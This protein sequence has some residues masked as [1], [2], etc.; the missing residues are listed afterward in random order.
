[1]TR[2][3]WI[4][5]AMLALIV[6][7][8]A[9]AAAAQQRSA[10]SLL[11]EGVNQ[12]L[13]MG[14]LT[15]AIATYRRILD[16]HARNR[17]VG[18]QAL[19]NLGRAY[20]KLGAAEA[21]AAYQRLLR[22]Y[23]DQPEPV[24]FARVRL[25]ALD[26]GRMVAG[27][28]ATA[29][30]YSMVFA[31]LPALRL[32]DAAH[33][34]FS[35]S[36]DQ[37]VLRMPADRSDAKLGAGL[38]VVSNGGVVLR[39]LVPARREVGLNNPRWSPDG[40]YIAYREASWVGADTSFG[41]IKI[42]PAEG[43]P[44]RT[45]TTEHYGLTGARGGFFWTP[46]SR[47]LTVVARKA[48]V[49]MDLAGKVIRTVPFE[50]YHLTQVTGYS[51]DGRWLAFHK[52]PP[53]TQQ[54][55]MNI[56]LMP[57]EGG[58]AIQLT[59][60]GEWNAWPTWT[61]DGRGLYFISDR[62]GSSNVWKIN[63]DPRSGL[64]QGEP[65]Q[66][67]SYTDVAVRHPRVLQGGK[68][69]FALIQETGTIRV[70]S[71]SDPA[72]TRALARGSDPRVSPDGQTVY[73]IGQ[74]VRPR[75]IFAVSTAEG[76]GAPRRVSTSG[77]DDHAFPSFSLSPDGRAVAFFSQDEGHA[78]LQVVETA[79]GAARELVRIASREQLVPA[80][81]PNGTQLAYSTGNAMYVIPAGPTRGEVRKIAELHDVEGWT[82]RW[83]PDGRHIA[84]L[85]WTQP[86]S[87]NAVVVVPASGG[88]PRRLTPLDERGYKEIVEWHPDGN[89]LTYMYYGNDD[90]ADET[91]VAYMDGRPTTLFVNQPYPIW[92]YVGVWHP[93]GRDYYFIAATQGSWSVYAHDENARATRLVWDHR[94]TSPGAKTP[95]FSRDGQTMAWETA[96]TAR[97]LWVMEGTR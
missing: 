17:R 32:R 42:I 30:V 74:G 40:Q 93:K 10:E 14:N 90:R 75:G 70:A 79:T 2:K 49:T 61:A 13:V 36:G 88:E 66:L 97:Q 54:E 96:T 85:A 81:S 95:S 3:H 35:P 25:E 47:A 5:G 22:E 68:L 12:E 84:A 33:Y 67:T 20:E 19:A 8:H 39:T 83:S 21:R 38:V 34:D 44:A 58:R 24:R 94:G 64:S 91:R 43:G 51:P 56:W 73:F 27:R 1:M 77:P 41:A 71:A 28:S 15:R 63:V 78:V 55:I 92:D 29:S 60:S 7:L 82:V 57:A 59:N 87:A 76:G 86:Q 65:V 23:A 4:P 80:W 16:Q 46:D 72:K 45:V 31:D 48:I 6:T 37:I 18:A 26:S 69:A 52:L 53:G 9:P 50:A 62:G 89:R 11:Q